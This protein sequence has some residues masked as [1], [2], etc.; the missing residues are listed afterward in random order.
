MHYAV[1]IPNFG[2]WSDPREVATF[3][4]QLEDAGWDGL[5]VWDHIV[6]MDGAEVADP[7]ILLAAAATAT[8]DLTLMNM[9]A[10]LPRR[11]PWK[12]ARETVSLDLL[13]SGR[14]ILGV[15]IGWPT[16]PEFARFHQEEDLRT[17]G[18]M[19]DEGLDVL[20]GLWSGEPFNYAGDHYQIDEVAFLPRPLQE[21][22]I[23]IW[24]AGMWPGGRPFRRAARF[25]GV[26]PIG[27]DGENFTEIGPDEVT[28]ILGVI[29]EHRD[30][31]G[32]YDFSL[33]IDWIQDRPSARE[34]IAALEIAGVTWVREQW[35]PWSG[36]EFDDW[37]RAALEGP[38]R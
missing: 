18:D 35:N 22:R 26:V 16:D 12:L 29:T 2:L 10:P 13:S 3:A 37:R 25:D 24:V 4:R 38:P 36:F 9:V 19:L 8:S 11:H 27:F 32:P 28:A 21:P 17:R 6:F 34:K 30:D 15:G 7:W 5:S 23:P 1:D 31:T 14:F 33:S 20:L